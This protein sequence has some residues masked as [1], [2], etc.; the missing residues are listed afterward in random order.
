MTSCT[1][2]TPTNDDAI[3]LY[4]MSVAQAVETGDTENMT[5]TA[6]SIKRDLLAYPEHY[7]TRII[8]FQGQ[9]VGMFIAYDT[10][11]VAEGTRGL[12]LECLYVVPEQRGQGFAKSVFDWLHKYAAS[13]DMAHIHWMGLRTNDLAHGFYAKMGA[14]RGEEWRIYTIPV[15]S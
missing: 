15:N 11:W 2:R 5:V 7:M 8:E 6:G 14:S 12:C 1:F 4:T 9:P 13:H 10:Y 3:L